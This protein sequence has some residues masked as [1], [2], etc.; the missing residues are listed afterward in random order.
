MISFNA[1]ALLGIHDGQWA[2]N[3]LSRFALVFPF[4]SPSFLFFRPASRSYHEYMHCTI[5]RLLFL[6]SFVLGICGEEGL[7]DG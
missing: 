3:R 6:P 7:R 5:E 2:G 4:P 1:S